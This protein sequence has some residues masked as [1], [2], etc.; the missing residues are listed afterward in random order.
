[1]RYIDGDDTPA[2]AGLG[3]VADV[4]EGVDGNLYEWVDGL[5]EWGEPIGFWQGLEEVPVDTGMSGLGAL[6]QASDGNLYQMHGLEADKDDDEDD[7]DGK[8]GTMGPKMGPGKRGEIRVAEGKRYRWVLG[9]GPGG[10]RSGFWRRLRPGGP[11]APGGAAPARARG[12][13]PARRPGR[14]GRPGVGAPPPPGAPRK[15]KKPFLKRLL[16][17]AKFA[18][19]FIP[20]IGP[21][22]SAGL[23]VA[24]KLLTKKQ[25]VAGDDGLGALYMASDGSLYQV[26]GIDEDE[27]RG[28]YDGDR[29]EG[30]AADDD[31][32]G[33]AADDQL[34]GV[35]E[36]GDTCGCGHPHVH[37]V[38]RDEALDGYVRDVPQRGMQGYV[39]ERAP[40]TRMFERN[41]ETPE[42][43]K[44]LW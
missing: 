28:L 16:P 5:S 22:V 21:A 17:F 37:G 19:S 20:G 24:D 34:V 41:R 3:F 36:F 18:T 15:K 14:P 25:G 43:W 12:A 2:M 10:K 26:H 9:V 23:T 29:I 35:D 42:N 40:R 31:L 8:E 38:G 27:L 39:L 33:F 11:A 30:L 1:M 7:D 44:P 4:H 6:Y 13:A 32:R